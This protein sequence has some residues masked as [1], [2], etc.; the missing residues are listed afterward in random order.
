ML[1]WRKMS[2]N[3]NQV[4]KQQAR[5]DRSLLVMRAFGVYSDA[6]AYDAIL[7]AAAAAREMARSFTDMARRIESDAQGKANAAANALGDRSEY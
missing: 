2:H 5:I 1:G 4:G 3:L 6:A 7:D